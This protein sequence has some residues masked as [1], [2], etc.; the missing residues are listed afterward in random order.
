M[1]QATPTPLNVSGLARAGTVRA[2]FS[3]IRIDGPTPGSFSAVT[4][5][6]SGQSVHVIVDVSGYF[7]VAQSPTV[8]DTSE[9]APA[10]VGGVRFYTLRDEEHRL[11]TEYQQ[12]VSIGTRV[13][14]DYF[15]FGN[16]L[17]AT[18]TAWGSAQGWHF[19][20]TDHLG[21]PRLKTDGAGNVVA[22]PKYRPFGERIDIVPEPGPELAGMERDTVSGDYYVHA[23]Y[24]RGSLGRFNSLDSVPGTPDSPASWNRYAYARNSPLTMLDP[25]GLD[26]ILFIRDSGAGRDVGHVAL[27]VFG[28]GYDYTYDFGRYHPSSAYGLLGSSGDGVMR[29]W[30]SNWNSFG[31]GSF[32]TAS[33]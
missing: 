27:R 29:V 24:Q 20:T 5:L 13:A 3:M 7:A 23:R 25:N 33:I 22:R 18:N 6:P 30:K 19:Y 28:K 26:A 11:S 1:G 16:R 32:R 14:K 8:T 10:A 4:D 9:K 15:Y 12:D 17:V 2:V 31:C 21:T